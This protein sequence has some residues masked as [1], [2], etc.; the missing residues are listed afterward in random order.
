M[1]SHV[2]GA[3]KACAEGALKSATIGKSENDKASAMA[4]PIRR[5]TFTWMSPSS[6]HAKRASRPAKQNVPVVKSSVSF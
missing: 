4:L 1:L 2:K 3:P 5:P 6:K